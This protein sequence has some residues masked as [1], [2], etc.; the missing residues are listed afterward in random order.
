MHNNGEIWIYI[1]SKYRNWTTVVG[2]IN[3]WAQPLFILQES[4]A[5]IYPLLWGIYFNIIKYL[6]L[7]TSLDLCGPSYLY[8]SKFLYGNFWMLEMFYGMN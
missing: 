4:I 7:K 5:I 3:T 2:N 6:R 1:W 8:G